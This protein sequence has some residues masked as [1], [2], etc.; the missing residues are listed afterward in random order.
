MKTVILYVERM[1]LCVV[2][3][4]GREVH[5]NCA[6]LGYYVTSSSNFLLTFRAT[7]RFLESHEDGTDNLSRT[8]G[9]EYTS[10][11]VITQKSAILKAYYL[12]R[13]SLQW[14]CD[15][16][17]RNYQVWER[18]RSC[19][20]LKYNIGAF[21]EVLRKSAFLKLVLNARVVLEPFFPSYQLSTLHFRAKN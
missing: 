8:V 14:L 17:I 9:K 5:E 6:L 11:C 12:R 21:L 18:R 4:F 3:G 15:S 10:L 13:S 7:Y 1:V 19:R 2:S 16:K 20:N